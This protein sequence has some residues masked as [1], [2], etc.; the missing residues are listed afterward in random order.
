M[1]FC[2]HSSRAYLKVI[3]SEEYS[4]LVQSRI[5][6]LMS[7]SLRSVTWCQDHRATHAP[8]YK[9]DR[10]AQMVPGTLTSLSDRQRKESVEFLC[11]SR[12][13]MTHAPRTIVSSLLAFVF[14][15]IHCRFHIYKK[16][17]WP[18]VGSVVGFS[19]GRRRQC[20]PLCQTDDCRR[21]FEGS[22]W[23]VCKVWPNGEI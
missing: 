12:V 23:M 19:V 6:T 7:S 22:R 4:R 3:I 21:R 20:W 17:C 1:L 11:S 14:L 8:T 15:S 16:E 9:Q 18:L 5:R 10:S 13:L 2:V